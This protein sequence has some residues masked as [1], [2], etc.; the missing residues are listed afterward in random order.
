LSKVNRK[1]PTQ[2]RPAR[3]DP[4]DALPEQHSLKPAHGGFDFG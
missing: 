1:R 2:V 3:L 4:V